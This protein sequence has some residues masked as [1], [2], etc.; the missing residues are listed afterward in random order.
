[1]KKTSKSNFRA[2]E[3]VKNRYG[4]TFKL[5][6]DSYIVLQDV[7]IVRIN[8]YTVNTKNLTKIKLENV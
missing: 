2:G 4:A 7:E 8:G 1:M 6:E 3:V 5:E